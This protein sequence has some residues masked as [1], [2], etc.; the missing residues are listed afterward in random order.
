MR[1]DEDQR[2]TRRECRLCGAELAWLG[3]LGRLLWLRC[4]DCGMDFSTRAEPEAEAG[5]DPAAKRGAK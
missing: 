4:R 2:A 5:E 3:R 1:D